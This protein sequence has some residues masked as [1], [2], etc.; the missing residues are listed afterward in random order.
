MEAGSL[1][2]D[3]EHRL[4]RIL[5]YRLYMFIANIHDMLPFTKGE[6][7]ADDDGFVR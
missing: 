4:W 1:P 2:E 6:W 7:T 5:P 3:L